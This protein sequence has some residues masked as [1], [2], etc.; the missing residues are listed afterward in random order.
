[1]NKE[2]YKKY[3]EEQYK[4]DPEGFAVYLNLLFEFL[5]GVEKRTWRA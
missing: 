4:D 5:K 1:M 3:V 2:E